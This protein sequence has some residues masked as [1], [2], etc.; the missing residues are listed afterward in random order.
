MLADHGVVHVE[1]DEQLP[2]HLNLRRVSAAV[3]CI[4]ADIPL[5][6]RVRTVTDLSR[7]CCEQLLILSRLC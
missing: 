7:L 5:L 2:P 6:Q 4:A 1:D 3:S